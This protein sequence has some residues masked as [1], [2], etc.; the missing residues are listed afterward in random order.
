MS[1]GEPYR[2]G[3]SCHRGCTPELA[4]ASRGQIEGVLKVSERVRATEP[5][6]QHDEQ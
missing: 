4:Y 3:L 6:D 5:V 2:A 1:S